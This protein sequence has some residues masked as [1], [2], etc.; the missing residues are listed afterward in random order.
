V[1]Y[2][3][4]FGAGNIERFDSAQYAVRLLLC[5]IGWLLVCFTVTVKLRPA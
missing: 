5:R 2:R 4:F 1:H 3:G